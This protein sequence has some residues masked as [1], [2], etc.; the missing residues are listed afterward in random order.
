MW[1]AMIAFW[2]LLIWAI[3]ALVTDITRR[4]G[5]TEQGGQR[6]PGDAWRILDDRLPAARSTP[7]STSGC[8]RYSAT[9]GAARPDPGARD[10]RRSQ[11]CVRSP[12]ARPVRGDASGKEDYLRRLRKTAN[13][14]S[15]KR[16]QLSHRVLSAPPLR[17]P[18]LAC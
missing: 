7:R 16:G 12:A 8:A 18:D 17:P 4:P 3:Y 10:D 15:G 14:L 1:L 6:Q 9:A 5:Q 11:G 13:R 2:A